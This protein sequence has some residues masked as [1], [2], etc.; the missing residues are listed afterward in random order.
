QSR[1]ARVRGS[2][3][4]VFRHNLRGYGSLESAWDFRIGCT[5]SAIGPR[6]V[7]RT[8]AFTIEAAFGADDLGNIGGANQFLRRENARDRAEIL[9]GRAEETLE[10][11]GI[12]RD[13]GPD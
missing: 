7:I 2:F 13:F 4:Y 12:V 9:P 8:S 5:P 3:P 6:T 10:R 1:G 11:H